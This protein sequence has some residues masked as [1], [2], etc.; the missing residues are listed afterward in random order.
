MRTMKKH[1]TTLLSWLTEGYNDHEVWDEWLD[2]SDR[3]SDK[4]VNEPCQH[5]NWGQAGF[6]NMGTCYDCGAQFYFEKAE[7][8]I[9]YYKLI[10][11]VT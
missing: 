9:T 4:K 3:L 1:L 8:G 11:N 7:D 2:I 10:E 6:T 5:E